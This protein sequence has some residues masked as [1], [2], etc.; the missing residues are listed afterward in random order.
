MSFKDFLQE[1]AQATLDEYHATPSA[2]VEMCLRAKSLKYKKKTERGATLFILDDE[3]TLRL[4]NDGKLELL[5]KDDQV[6]QTV[7]TTDFE[8]IPKKV[9]ELLEK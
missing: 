3:C 8:K 2:K 9:D 6:I 4:F 5:D 7:D 1:N